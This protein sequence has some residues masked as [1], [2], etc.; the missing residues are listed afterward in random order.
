MTVLEAVAL[1]GLM[2]GELRAPSGLKGFLAM[3][4]LLPCQPNPVSAFPDVGY[5]VDL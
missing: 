4:F 3:R 2:T 1:T 5:A